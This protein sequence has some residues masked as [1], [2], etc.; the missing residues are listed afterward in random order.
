MRTMPSKTGLQGYAIALL[1]VVIALLASYA[2]RPLSRSA[3]WVFCFAAVI[4]TAWFGGRRSSFVATLG[5]RRVWP[6][7]L[8]DSLP[9]TLAQPR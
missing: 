3:P 9:L 2:T 7:F 6:L 4:A 1:A 5:S 8:H